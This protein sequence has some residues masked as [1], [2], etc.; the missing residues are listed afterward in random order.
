MS[1]LIK[2]GNLADLSAVRPIG[3]QVAP[4]LVVRRPEDEEVERF[5][6]AV[7]SLEGELRERDVAIDVLRKDVERAF[8]EG[9]AKG[10]ELGRSEAE[11]RESDRLA[12]LEEGI[13][14][15][16]REVCDGLVSLERLAALLAR[17]CLEKI[18]GDATDRIDLIARIVA[19]QIQAIDRSMLLHIEVS[20]EDFP[21][22]AAL[23]SLASRLEPFRLLPVVNA[24]LASGGCV[25]SLRLGRMVVGLDQQW[26]ALR[27]VL[28][29]M[30]LPEEAA[31]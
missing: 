24:D 13:E 29:E 31:P 6:R 19:A 3:V 11:D 10:R 4:A 17:E 27:G 30:A 14:T 15:A 22:P 25:M 23:A 21:N 16:R 12:R 9:R 1:A 5:R 18:L 20:S 8:E 2:S 26:G 28:N 7:S